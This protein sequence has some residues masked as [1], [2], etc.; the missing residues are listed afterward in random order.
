MVGENL[1]G[2]QNSAKKAVL[3]NIVM[4][5]QLLAFL[6]VPNL[7]LASSS[8]FLVKSIKNLR[9]LPVCNCCRVLYRV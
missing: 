7:A 5:L 3:K 6:I 8:C 2:N 4:R 9:R 1:R